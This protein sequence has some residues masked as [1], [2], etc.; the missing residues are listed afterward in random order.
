M[1][2]SQSAEPEEGE[3]RV[4]IFTADN[5]SSTVFTARYEECWS[6]RVEPCVPL[7]VAANILDAWTGGDP[8]HRKYGWPPTDRADDDCVIAFTTAAGSLVLDWWRIANDAEVYSLDALPGL[9]SGHHY[10]LAAR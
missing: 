10:T 7:E 6:G 3:Q 1:T 2:E 9:L 4:F 8:D 5:G